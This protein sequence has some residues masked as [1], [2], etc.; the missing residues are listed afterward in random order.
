MEQDLT[1]AYRKAPRKVRAGRVIMFIGCILFFISALLDIAAF[2]LMM[3]FPSIRDA[4]VWDDL[5]VSIQRFALP[6]LG[7]FFVF[8]GIGG[9]S[10]IL[11]KGPFKR[12]ATLTAIIML[13]F[14]VLDT[15]I[16]VRNF[17]HALTEDGD[18]V[19]S[20][21]EFVLNLIDIQFSGGLY[22][23]GWFMIKDYTGD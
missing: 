16:S 1:L 21:I 6:V 17:I 8:A 23:I 4:L 7:I 19:G 3:F 11:D 10:Y 5:S 2:A 22:F 20:I 12:I 18:T 15:I 9:I 13:V 14:F